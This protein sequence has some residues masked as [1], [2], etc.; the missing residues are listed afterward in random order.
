M[1]YKYSNQSW[2]KNAQQRRK[3]IIKKYQTKVNSSNVS[4]KK[5]KE[6]P[7]SKRFLNFLIKICIVGIILGSVTFAG[8]FFWYS[9]ELP[10]STDLLVRDTNTAKFYDRTGETLLYDLGSGEVTRTKTSLT[11]IPDY[12]KWATIVAEDRQ[13]YSHHGINFKGILRAVFTNIFKRKGGSPV[14]G[15]S[16]SQQFIKNALLTPEKT[17]TRKFKELILTWQLER[18]FTKDE[19]LEMYLNEI[20]YGGTAYGIEAAS[21]KYFD[22]S[23]NELSLAEIAVL[24]ALPQAPSY[25]SPYGSNKDKLIARKDWILDSL[26]EEGYISKEQAEKAKAEELEFSKVSSSI[27]APHFIFYVKELVAAELGEKALTEDGLKIITTLDIDKQI[28]AEK[29]IAEQTEKNQEKYN[30]S[31]AALV[32][33]KADSGEILSMV[34]SADYFNEDIDGAVNVALRP[35]QPGS[36][37]KPIVYATAFEKGFTPQTILFDLITVFKTEVG[38]YEPHNYNDTNF[39][40]VSIKKALAGSL[41]VP[42]VKTIYLVGIENVLNLAEKL[43]YTTFADRSRFGLSLVLGGGEV[44]LLE[45]TAAF[46]ALSQDGEYFKPR[47]ILKIENSDSKTLREFKPDKAKGK[48]T[49]DEQVA[50]QITDILSDNNARAYVFGEVNLLTLP[51]RPVA[52]KTGTT[53]DYKDGWTM[54]YTPDIVTGVWVGNAD[55]KNMTGAA[56]GGNVAAPIWNRFMQFA[57]QDDE[58]KEFKKPKTQDLPEKPM[59]NGSLAAEIKIKI[60]KT[61]GKLA[62]DLTPVSQ[63]E[64][65]TFREVHSILHYVNKNNPLGP[66]PTEPWQDENYNSWEL[67]VQEWAAENGY[68]TSVP[69]PTEEDDIHTQENI[70]QLEIISP[71]S[72]TTLTS[73]ELSVIIEASAKRG[74]KKV[75]YWLDENKLTE[76]TTSP[77]NLSEFPLI[78][79]SNGQHNLRVIAKDDVDNQK[80]EAL[81]LNLNLASQYTQPVTFISPK[82]EDILVSEN[83]PVDIILNISN[84]DYYEKVDLYLIKPDGSSDWLNWKEIK[85]QEINIT[86]TDKPKEN[87]NYKIYALTTSNSGNSIK[88]EEINLRIE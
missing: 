11:D 14:G 82:N 23:I 70:P 10:K 38:D 79:F 66:I 45:H 30:A 84:Q 3:Q 81:I 64:E 52:A 17:L 41:N 75:E 44:K 24:T 58:V 39:G 48:K 21:R 9:K 63:I 49:M 33:L 25:L 29:I 32:C 8:A 77:F 54:G 71:S 55:G 22:K 4:S 15:S 13:F 57:T 88:S 43:G 83:F 37:F 31:N 35:R 60:D 18:K 80:V 19:I 51:L 69:L 46:T 12:V 61:T 78:G 86:W 27:I 26:A 65:K 34:G 50:R 56:A 59:L 2:K 68:E 20:P 16:I 36:S 76:I 72:N 40:P 67:A 6:K 53:N 87:G 73:P 74:V 47:A 62:T 1:Y 42:A 28:E 85:K 7:L 5:R